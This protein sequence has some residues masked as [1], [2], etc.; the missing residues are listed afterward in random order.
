[1]IVNTVESLSV[2][3]LATKQT[4]SV[5]RSSGQELNTCYIL[6]E[7][8]NLSQVQ[9]QRP[10]I[11]ELQVQQVSCVSSSWTV[12]SISTNTLKGAYFERMKKHI[13]FSKIDCLFAH[14]D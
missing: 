1:M 11:Q 2:R 13:F 9:V 12:A 14:N 7:L 6:C 3:A 8:E 10:H 4:G 5:L